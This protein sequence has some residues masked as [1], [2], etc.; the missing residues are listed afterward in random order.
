MRPSLLPSEN[1]DTTKKKS[2][3][4]RLFWKLNFAVHLGKREQL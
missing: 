3:R 2:V 4:S 1:I